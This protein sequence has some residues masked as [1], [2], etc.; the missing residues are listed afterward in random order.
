MNSRYRLSLFWRLFLPITLMILCAGSLRT[1]LLLGEERAAQ[2]QSMQSGLN[3]AAAVMQPIIAEGVITGDYASIQAALEQQVRLRPNIQRAEWRMESARLLAARPPTAASYPDG[4]ARLSGIEVCELHQPIS[5]AGADYGELALLC[6]PAPGRAAAW[7]R[8]VS[9]AQVVSGVVIALFLI[10]G[11]I[12]RTSLAAL[13]RLIEA[14]RRFPEDHSTRVAVGGSRE[15]RLLGQAFNGMAE[16]VEA[17]LRALALARARWEHEAELNRTTLLSIGDA[18]ITTDAEGR[19][20]QLN[21]VAERLTGWPAVEAAGQPL[22]AIFAIVNEQ[23]RAPVDNPV[24]RVLAEGIVVGLANHTVLIARDGSEQP[25]EDSAAPIRCGNGEIVGCVLVFHDV[26]EKKALQKRIGW[27]ATH[28]DLTGLPNRALLADR[29]KQAVAR[30]DRGQHLLAVGMLDLDEFKPVNDRL[31]HAAG[32][33]LLRLVTARTL[34]VLRASDTLARLGGDEFVLVLPDLA[35]LAEA[36]A[37]FGRLL[38]C[39]AQPYVLE[40]ET[41]RVTATLGF[42]LYPLDAS[43]PDTLLRHA[44]EAMYAA[45]HAG[46]NRYHLYDVQ[47][48][49]QQQTRRERAEDLHRALAAGEFELFYQPKVDLRRGTVAGFEALARWR[50][51]LRGIVPPADFLPH[52]EG[53]ELGCELGRFALAAALGQIAAWRAAGCDWRVSVNIS[54]QHFTAPHFLDDLKAAL[55]RHPDVPPQRL[56]LEILESAAIADIEQAASV[57][58]ACH[59]LGIRLALDDFGTGYASLAY[60]KRLP[61]D[62]L[63]IDQSFVRDVLDDPGDLAVVEA[64]IT[65][66]ALFGRDVVAEGVELAEQGV[67]LMRLGCD[68]AQGYGIAR[69]MPAAEVAAWAASWQPDPRWALWADAKWEMSDFPL[70]VAQYD[71]LRWVKSVLAFLDG[72]RLSLGREELADH[73]ACRLGHWYDGHGRQRYGHLAAF[74][75]M[76]P[77]HAEVHRTG[78]EIIRLKAD[79]RLQE[80]QAQARHLLE[81]KDRILEH[82]ARLQREMLHQA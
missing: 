81:L 67:L 74:Q 19:V 7:I 58:A 2:N 15:S 80:A 40:G 68:I 1:W 38:D 62:E 6:D 24:A 52:M 30:C 31:G 26:S 28:D 33:Q 76:E 17:T 10:L 66:A 48:D 69:P 22:T 9:Q 23:T 64:V 4:F 59:A 71:H 61:A 56:M 54:P 60:L 50:H 82:L 27:Q 79:G 77:V 12:L 8:V 70:L 72:N 51:P 14:H 29:L 41:V 16:E 35:T 20:A 63:K 3:L 13:R 34:E 44:D 32:D 47:H 53:N 37:I 55:A 45:K 42:T 75:E 65:L 21:P 43:D 57:I 11:L 5:L 18:V 46:R 25:I 78:C 73:H 49:E 36:E 39:L